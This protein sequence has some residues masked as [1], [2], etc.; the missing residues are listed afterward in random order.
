MADIDVLEKLGKA[1]AMHEKHADDNALAILSTPVLYDNGEVKDLVSFSYIFGAAMLASCDGFSFGYGMVLINSAGTYPEKSPNSPRH[2][3]HTGFMTA[4][5]ELGAFVGCLTVAT[6]FFVVGAIIQTAAPNYDAL[7][8][9]RLIGS[10]GV[11]AL[12][13]GAPLHISEFALPNWRGSLLVME[14]INIVL[15]AI[16]T[17][18]AAYGTRVMDTEWSFRPPFLQIVRA[19]VVGG[20]IHL[21]PFS[22]RWL[23]MRSRNAGSLT[24]LARLRILAEIRFQEEIHD[25]EYPKHKDQPVKTDLRQWLGLFNKRYLRRTLVALAIPFFQQFSGIDAIVYYAPTGQDRDRSLVLSG[26]IN[27]VQFVGSMHMLIYLDRAGRRTLAIIGGIAMAIPH[28]IMSGLMSRFSSDWPSNRGIAWS[29]VALIY[30]YVFTYAASYGLLAWV[31]P[32]E[33][34]PSS[35]RA[36]EVSAGT[37]MIWLANFIVGVMVPDMLITLGWGTFLFFDLFCVAATMLS[38]LFVPET[39]E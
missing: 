32:A 5:L 9:G 15:G 1:S 3:V 31:S 28:L 24:A 10:I 21:F 22:P 18:R 17:Y 25:H 13:K 39:F 23:A 11:G 20:A 26:M 29:C 34:F 30:L 27:I 33:I 2:G 6:A 4:M 37:A 7:I 36:K 16:V 12:A 14:A 19:L 8:A 38:F 35:Q